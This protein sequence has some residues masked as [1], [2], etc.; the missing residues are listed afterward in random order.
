[1]PPR[2]TKPA[3]VPDE[4]KNLVDL[5]WRFYVAAQ[6]PTTRRIAE[7]IE[8][9]EDR[10]GSANHETVRRTLRGEALG[11][12][13]TVEVIFLALCEI[14][15]V[16]PHDIE[17]D[18]EYYDRFNP[19]PSVTMNSAAGTGTKPWTGRRCPTS[20]EP[21]RSA[22]NRKRPPKQR[23]S[24]RPPLDPGTPTTSRRSRGSDQPQQVG[25]G[26][27]FWRAGSASDA[28]DADTRARGYECLTRFRLAGSPPA[29]RNNDDRRKTDAR[30][31]CG[32]PVHA[33]HPLEY[34]P[35]SRTRHGGDDARQ[36]PAPERAH[37]AS[38][39]G[40]APGIRPG[41]IGLTLA[42]IRGSAWDVPP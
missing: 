17:Y 23:P 31:R 22:T 37:V 25:K 41:S 29:H 34:K 30:R 2:L 12:W 8:A 13:W 35:H 16:D 42:S 26:S 7:T 27:G 11:A 33:Q 9:R 15:D 28:V 5:L 20:P 18:E 32:G 36:Y 4:R 3:S 14:A 19:P 6:R 38:V 10:R 24:A 21:A 40:R 1:M 39:S